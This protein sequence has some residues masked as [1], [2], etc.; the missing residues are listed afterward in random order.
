MGVLRRCISEQQLN[1]LLLAQASMNRVAAV[2]AASGLMALGFYSG[3]DPQMKFHLASATG[4]L[5]RLLDPETS[6]KLGILAAKL[7]LFPKENR[8]DPELLK[9]ELWG[10]QFPN[11]LG[12]RLTLEMAGWRYSTPIV[13]R[14]P[15]SHELSTQ[16]LP[17]ALTKMLKSWSPC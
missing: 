12:E 11:P 15:E 10:K 13:A 4:P 1:K 16:A 7:G 8:K 14:R 3:T 5:L 6:H 2:G 17:L 9:V